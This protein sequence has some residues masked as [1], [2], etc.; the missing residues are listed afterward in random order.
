MANEW[1]YG[2]AALRAADEL[3]PLVY[4][5]QPFSSLKDSP[6]SDG[7]RNNSIIM[8]AAAHAMLLARHLVVVGLWEGELVIE[9][10]M[11]IREGTFS[12]P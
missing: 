12:G 11:T 2:G 8:D 1:H 4:R 5:T 10:A 6:P 9:D 7:H 3:I